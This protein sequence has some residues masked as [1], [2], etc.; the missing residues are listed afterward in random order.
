MWCPLQGLV[1]VDP[2][3]VF[4]RCKDLGPPILTT[5]LVI[6]CMHSLPFLCIS[7]I[8]F[9]YGA[10]VTL[11]TDGGL[12]ALDW[13][14]AYGWDEVSYYAMPVLAA[15]LPRT[16]IAPSLLSSAVRRYSHNASL[17]LMVLYAK[18]HRS[19]VRNCAL[20]EMCTNFPN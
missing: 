11:Y 17:M 14:K 7:I 13:A 18:L 4:T 5:C 12:T 15:A 3:G 6:L 10:D 16:T 19:S 9:R 8:D 2:S 20:D 1:D